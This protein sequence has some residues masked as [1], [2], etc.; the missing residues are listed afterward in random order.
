MDIFLGILLLLTYF[1]LIWYAVK[2][3]NLMI[4]FFIMAILWILI[5]GIHYHAAV[6]TVIEGG[7]ESYAVTAL[8]V[9]FGSWFGRI[10]V[11]TGIAGTIIRKTVELGGDKPLVVTILLSIV[12]SLIFTS[13]FGVGAVIAIGVIILPILLSLGVPKRVA[14]SSFTLAVGA[15]MYVNIVLFK[16]IQLF[17]PSVKYG[18]SWLHFGFVAMAIQVI[19]IIAMLAFNLRPSKLQRAWAAQVEPSTENAPVISF[20][21][22]IIPVLMA[23]A[24]GWQP[25]PAILL[26]I[27]L[28][29]LL[30]K[31]MFNVKEA[32]AIIQKTLYDGVADVGLLLGM[33]FMLAMFGK[34]AGMDAHIFNPLISPVIPHSAL[35]LAI[36]LG[37]VAPL[38]LF[39]GPLMVFGAGSATVAILS[40]LHTFSPAVLLPLVYIPTISMAISA[41]ATQSWNLWAINYTKLT[42]KEFL[43]TGVFWAWVV[44]FINEV[45]AALMFK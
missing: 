14:A 26:A 27:I 43:K 40:S 21:V 28:A 6:N 33:L 39:R 8:V 22:P 32:V 45:V 4:G 12:T 44:V 5:G 30:T 35:V 41:D 19:F 24:F 17:F 2:G 9:I 34:A 15:G 10:I 11:D 20:I 7:A 25:V 13:T 29:L 31:K 3:G 36:I 16:Q 37:I 23:I 18:P 1:G 42:V 38:A